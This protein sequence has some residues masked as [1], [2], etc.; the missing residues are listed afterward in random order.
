MRGSENQSALDQYLRSDL[1]VVEVRNGESQ[2]ETWRRYLADHP[3]SVGARVRI[4]HYPGPAP[5]K[6]PR[7]DSSIF[8][9][10]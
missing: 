4:F 2:E 1:A 10:P 8:Q 7:A 9:V 3:E 5:L 6:N